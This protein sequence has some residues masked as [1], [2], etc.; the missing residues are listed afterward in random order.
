MYFLQKLSGM[1]KEESVRIVEYK[2]IGTVSF[3]RKPS[4]RNLKITIKPFRKVLVTVP[5]FV[6]FQTA[7]TFVEEKHQWIKQSQAR[8][9]RYHKNITIFDEGTTFRTQDHLLILGRH[10]RNVIQTIIRNG[11]ITVLFPEHADTRDPRIQRAVRKAVQAAWRLEAGRHLPDMVKELALQYQFQYGDLTFRNNK[12]R[13]GSCARNNNISLNIHLMRLPKH[14][15]EYVI[16]HELCHT[17]H[18]HHQKAFW[19]LLNSITGGRARIMDR[20]L[21]GFSPEAW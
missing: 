4:V 2:E 1:F 14:L 6:S 21:N 15:C 10:K 18:K 19:Q 9:D 20:E 16:L 13:W 11:Q 17:V 5:R 3:I 12:T 7:V 8:F